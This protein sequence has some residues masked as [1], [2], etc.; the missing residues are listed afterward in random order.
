MYNKRLFNIHTLTYSLHKN[1]RLSNGEADS[2]CTLRIEEFPNKI[3]K[4]RTH[5]IIIY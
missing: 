2:G 3:I 5:L 1:V 4:Q